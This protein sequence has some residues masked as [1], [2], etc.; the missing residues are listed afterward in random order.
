MPN[1]KTH[2][3]AGAVSFLL[4]MHTVAAYLPTFTLP[5]ELLP[6]GLLLSL[7]G[8][9]FPDIDVPSKM[10][11]W[12]FMVCIIGI[13]GAIFTKNHALLASLGISILFVAFL[14]HR[15]IT[16]KPFFLLLLG[17]IPLSFTI[18]YLPSQAIPGAALYLYFTLGCLSHVALDRLLTFGKKLIGKGRRF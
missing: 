16:H 1:Y 13:L 3:A 4:L 5:V 12:F 7:V 18:Y 11:K 2:L 8:S 15:T 10:Q 6:L 9:I 14:T 17:L